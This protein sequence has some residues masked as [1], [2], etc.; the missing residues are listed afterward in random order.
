MGFCVS[1]ESLSFFQGKFYLF[2]LRLHLLAEFSHRGLQNESQDRDAV[3]LRKSRSNGMQCVNCSMQ[4][5]YCFKLTHDSGSCTKA[6]CTAS[7][8]ISPSQLQ[9]DWPL[10]QINESLVHLT[11]SLILS[12]IKVIVAIRRISCNK[13]QLLTSKAMTN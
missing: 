4:P 2:I 12:H 8:N 1:S 7:L 5:T 11:Y 6:S 9:A 10:Y 3:K 13:I